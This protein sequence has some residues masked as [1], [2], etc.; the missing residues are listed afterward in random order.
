MFCLWTTLTV[1]MDGGSVLLK[2]ATL[3]AFQV[4][5]VKPGYLLP[6]HFSEP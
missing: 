6:L 5:A 4:R 2:D 3:E 1:G